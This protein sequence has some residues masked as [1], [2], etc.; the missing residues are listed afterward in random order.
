V[1]PLQSIADA[2]LPALIAKAPLSDAKVTF[3][4][5]TAVGP[6]IERN[7]TVTLRERT[8]IVR[9][10]NPTWT[11]EIE[12]SRDLILARVQHLLGQD[13]VRRIECHPAR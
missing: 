7:T 12:R 13:V 11:R 2:V 4:W 8:L 3:A 9:V 10:S 6:A 5:R 1:K